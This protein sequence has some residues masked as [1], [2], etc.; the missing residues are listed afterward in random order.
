MMKIV[1]GVVFIVGFYYFFSFAFDA[2]A[3]LKLYNGVTVLE[4]PVNLI[5]NLAM[6]VGAGLFNIWILILLLISITRGSDFD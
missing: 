3:A 1:L 5:Y 2:K 4:V 6:M